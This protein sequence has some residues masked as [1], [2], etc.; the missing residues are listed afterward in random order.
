MR[1]LE[2]LANLNRQQMQPRIEIQRSAFQER[3]EREEFEK[4]AFEA[5]KSSVGQ[6]TSKQNSRSY[7]DRLEA[8]LDHK[9]VS[10]E[11]FLNEIRYFFSSKE[12]TEVSDWFLFKDTQLVEQVRLAQN[13]EDL[14]RIWQDF[15]RDFIAQFN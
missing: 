8:A 9:S 14:Q 12:D 15:R 11:K 2:L 3:K 1:N 10:W 6:Y 7:C 13:A 4:N 5:V